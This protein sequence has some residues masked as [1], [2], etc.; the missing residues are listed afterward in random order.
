MPITSAIP[1]IGLY[2]E[3]YGCR[4]K[5]LRTDGYAFD[6][7]KLGRYLMAVELWVDLIVPNEEARLVLASA[8][9]GS[10]KESWNVRPAIEAGRK[11]WVDNEHCEPFAE[12]GTKADKTVDRSSAVR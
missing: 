9:V 6:Q 1:P 11:L 10:K 7:N 12:L 5:G 2:S 3:L 8:I 4:H